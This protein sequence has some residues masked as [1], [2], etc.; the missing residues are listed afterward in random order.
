MQGI[1]PAVRPALIVFSLILL[2]LAAGLGLS[3]WP[4]GAQNTTLYWGNSGQDVV[5]V[6][7]RLR[8][9]GYYHGPVDGF[10]GADMQRAVV[11]YQLANGLPPS[12]VVDAAT[13]ETLGYAPPATS[14]APE[15]AGLS[16]GIS[17]RDSVYLLAKVI[18][19]E[20]ANEPFDGKVAV[21]AVIVNR[22]RSAAFPHSLSGVIY[23]PDAFESVSNGQYNRPVSSEALRAAMLAVSGWDPTGGA[24]YFWNPGKQVSPWIWS[25]D[26]ITRI[27]D[28]VFA[29]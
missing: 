16:R 25:R 26:V 20:A 2:A 18:E 11:D 24:I 21:G 6:Q 28:Q 15:P 3:G 1:F 22:T 27:G 12:G 10:Y 13:W 19:G 14:P 23:Q 7:N 4:A 9:W 17:N 29:R 8:D 5:R